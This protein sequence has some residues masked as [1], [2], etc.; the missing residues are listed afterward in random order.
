M[1]EFV[2]YFGVLCIAFIINGY[3]FNHKIKKVNDRINQM[4]LPLVC[5]GPARSIVSEI[6]YERAKRKIDALRKGLDNQSNEV[7]D[8]V[9][10]TMVYSN[11]FRGLTYEKFEISFPTYQYEHEKRWLSE[12]S[13]LAR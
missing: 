3:I 7:L 11:Y 4:N 6:F 10:A 2:L 9:L 1:I 8:Y 5:L 13:Q 12:K